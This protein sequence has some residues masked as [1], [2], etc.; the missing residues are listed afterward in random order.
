[1]VQKEDTK[2]EVPMILNMDKQPKP[3]AISHS[4]KNTLFLSG[5]VALW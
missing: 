1:M 5:A 2:P 4:G 3:L